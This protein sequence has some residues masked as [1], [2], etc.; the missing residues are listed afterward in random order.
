M[1]TPEEIDRLIET[2]QP[3]IDDLNAFITA[4]I[5]KRLMARIKHGDPFKLSRSDIWQIELL[6][7]TNAHFETVQKKIAAWTG[8]ADSEIAAIFEDAGIT[9]WEAD[10]K[11]YEANGKKTLPINELPRMVQIMQDTMQRTYGTF[12]NF[13]QTTAHASQQRF[14]KILDEVHLKA[15]TGAASY[16]EAVRDAVNELCTTQ[17]TVTYGD[18]ADGQ[19]VRHKDTVETATLRAVRTGT[20]QACGNISMQGMM[21]ND[22]DV[23]QVSGHMGA[24]YG[25]GGHNPGNHFWWQAKLYS[26]TGQTKGLPKFEVCGYGSGEGL[27]GWNCRHSFGPGTLGF[28]PYDKFDSEKNKKAYDLSQKQRALERRI[29][30]DKAD[31]AGRDTALKNCPESEKEKYNADYD[32][33]VARLKK[34]MKAY[35]DFCKANGLKKLY[36]RL[37]NAKYTRLMRSGKL[38]NKS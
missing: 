32:S 3:Y 28:N 2:M 15:V 16:Q 19:Y 18:A 10:R 36:D 21:D 22:W 38:R 24:R 30:R 5:I 29:R 12:H 7:E 31:V 20:A 23:I 6:R 4:D 37:E 25:D 27:C 11:I 35:N 14:I 33:S 17:L 8:K 26:R 34:H 1:L 13:T 9:A